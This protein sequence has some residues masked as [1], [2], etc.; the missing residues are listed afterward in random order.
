MRALR[1]EFKRF[2]IDVVLIEPG[3]IRTGWGG[4][5]A[6]KLRATSGHRPLCRAR[7]GHGDVAGAELTAE[8]R[9]TSR[10]EVIAKAVSEAA[11][12]QRSRIR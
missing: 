9:M 1:L 8:A 6:E 12:A 11:T 2:G 5:A 3:S 10:A 7:Q 4:I